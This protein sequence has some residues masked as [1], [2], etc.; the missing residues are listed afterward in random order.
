MQ[1]DMNNLQPL[2]GISTKS[3]HP[4][5]GLVSAQMPN[6]CIGIEREITSNRPENGIYF[7]KFIPKV[8]NV[9]TRITTIFKINFLI[10]HLSHF[11]ACSF[12]SSVG[13]D[14]F[15]NFLSRTQL[16]S[17]IMQ[18]NPKLTVWVRNCDSLAALNLDF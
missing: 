15:K 6:F 7:T 11:C 4:R 10:F 2:L 12:F 5:I 13:F 14:G 1:Y 16:C 3:D 9:D 17:P 18:R 8:A